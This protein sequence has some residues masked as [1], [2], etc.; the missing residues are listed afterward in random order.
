MSPEARAAVA[1]DPELREDVARSPLQVAVVTPLIARGRTFGAV[2]CISEPRDRY[3][4]DDLAFINEL[5]ARAAT[6]IDNARLYRDAQAAEQR[7][8]TLFAGSADVL[9]VTDADAHYI[10]ANP[11]AEQLLGFTRDELLHM[12]V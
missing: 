10:D 7:Y 8:R 9:L 6:A 11:A 4:A 5:A 12:Q 1:S 3:S 2:S